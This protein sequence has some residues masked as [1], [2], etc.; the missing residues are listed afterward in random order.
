MTDLAPVAQSTLLRVREIR[1]VLSWLRSQESALAAAR[2][3]AIMVLVGEGLSYE[4]IA[5]ES[6]VTR[7]RVGQIVQQ[8]RAEA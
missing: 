3:E 8:A 5:K 7:G 4:T 1:T 2:D 6:G